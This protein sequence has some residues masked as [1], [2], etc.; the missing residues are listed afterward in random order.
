MCLIFCG[1]LVPTL[2]ATCTLCKASESRGEI[3]SV[4]LNSSLTLAWG[5]KD[6]ERKSAVWKVA[7]LLS[8][9]C[10]ETKAGIL[11]CW[12]HMTDT[13]GSALLHQAQEIGHLCIIEPSS[14]HVLPWSS[15]YVGFSEFVRRSGVGSSLLLL[16]AQLKL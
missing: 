11:L 15:L 6:G 3:F 7:M 13:G 1:K 9:L 5:D 10:V 4:S 8:D 16:M 14:P 2:K 12:T